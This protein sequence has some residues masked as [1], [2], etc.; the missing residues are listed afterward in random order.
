M[1]SLKSLF[2]G[3]V[4]LLLGCRSQNLF[5]DSREFRGL[6]E[7]AARAT[8]SERARILEDMI[9]PPPDPYYGARNLGPT[10][11]KK[12]RPA[13]EDLSIGGA[14]GHIAHAYATSAHVIGVCDPGFDVLKA[15][16]VWLYCPK[17]K[18]LRETKVFYPAS[19]PW[20]TAADAK[21]T[22]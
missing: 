9:S 22:P 5:E 16:I 12:N 2:V 15:Q 13:P 11:D 8:L 17:S 14:F 19:E 1:Y 10:C 18:I 7:N 4:L 21:C 3:A 20:R 6:D